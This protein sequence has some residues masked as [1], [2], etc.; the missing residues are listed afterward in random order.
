MQEQFVPYE[1]ALALKELGFNEECFGCYFHNNTN[2]VEYN[3]DG[4]PFNHNN[5]NSRIS[6]PLWQQAFDWFRDKHNLPVCLLPYIATKKDW[7][8]E[9]VYIPKIYTYEGIITLPMGVYEEARLACL[10]KLIEKFTITRV[11]VGQSELEISPEIELQCPE[12]ESYDII[13]EG[14]NYDDAQSY[15]S[16]NDCD[17]YGNKSDFE[18]DEDEDDDE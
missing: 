16:C 13:D 17:H 7:E 9:L 4:L 10:E 8:E 11:I 2:T 12:C 14:F 1:Q 15:C 18:P 6:A 5:R 3:P